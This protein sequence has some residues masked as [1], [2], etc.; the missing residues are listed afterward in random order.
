MECRFRRCMDLRRSSRDS[1]LLRR[2]RRN[3]AHIFRSNVLGLKP[4]GLPVLPDCD[5]QPEQFMF[6]E[7]VVSR[8]P[9]AFEPELTISYSLDRRAV[10]V[11]ITFHDYIVSQFLPIAPGR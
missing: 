1:R 7:S 10:T 11:P 6:A 3:L 2:R 5:G 9:Q 4:Y 8:L